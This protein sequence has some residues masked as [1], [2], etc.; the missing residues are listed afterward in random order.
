[1]VFIRGLP[2][3][4]ASIQTAPHITVFNYLS[5]EDLALA[6]NAA[7]TIVSRPGYSS[8]MDIVPLQK[9]YIVI[10]TPGQAEQVYLANWLQQQ[11]YACTAPQNNF[12]LS[13]LIKQAADLPLH[14]QP[15][16]KNGVLLAQLIALLIT[17][18]HTK[19][20]ENLQ[21]VPGATH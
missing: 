6:V 9:K 11:G 14:K 7:D 12:S 8:V 5:G 21:Q 10:P 19:N 1:V 18:I 3:A 16:E 20:G 4:R 17:T 15:F 13:L 2:A